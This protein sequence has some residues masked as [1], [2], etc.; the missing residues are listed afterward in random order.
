M[1]DKKKVCPK[2]GEVV[3]I[4]LNKKD[5]TIFGTIFGSIIGLIFGG[6]IGAS[7]GI[8]ML[9]MAISGMLPL[10]I[11]GAVILGLVGYVVG[12][13]DQNKCSKCGAEL[14]E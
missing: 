12:I 1:E 3:D 9:G 2:C 8:A 10:A 5:K 13:K 7:I 6:W 14:A 11:I 4:P